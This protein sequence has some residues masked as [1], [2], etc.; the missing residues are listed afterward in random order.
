LSLTLNGLA[1]SDSF[2]EASR[3]PQAPVIS[4][5]RGAQVRDA[6]FVLRID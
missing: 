3:A 4:T 5:T 2:V 6:V 1:A